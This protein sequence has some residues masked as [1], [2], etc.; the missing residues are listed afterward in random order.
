VTTVLH[1]GKF[2]PPVSG[3]MERV[4]ESLCRATADRVANRV[5]VFNE[6][7]R[8]VREVVD[9]V[10]VTRVGVLGMAG[11]VPIAP[12]L[13]FEL[14]R[15][16]ADLIVV[17]EP[18][19]WALLAIAAVRPSI[20]IAVWFHSE[21]VRPR[22][23]YN[24]FYHPLAHAVYTRARRFIVSSPAL[25]EQAGALAPFRD[26]ISV[27]P[28]GIDVEAWAAS[29][30]TTGRARE[31]RAGASGRPIILF[32]GRMVPYKGVDV[33]LRALQGLDAHLI[34]AGDGPSSAAWIAMAGALGLQDRVTFTGEVPQG[35]LQALFHACD[36][37]VLPS[38]TR[39]EAF[40]YVQL[41]AMSCGKPVVSTRVE[42]GVPWVNVH[43]ETGLT[44]PPGDDVALRDALRRLMDDGAL[45]ARMGMAGRNRVLKEFT[46]EAMGAKTAAVYER[47]RH[48]G[49]RVL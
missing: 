12:A 42:S 21:V 8:T 9:G 34:L 5:L 2:Y 23:Q 35:E 44:V 45:R 32:A 6:G 22:L 26:R 1:V 43:E 37:F 31:I 24:L 16:R 13:G 10:P 18:N 4:L 28:F 49:A 36:L 38:V 27:V 15:S 19:P 48:D 14:K 30:R 7:R 20:P 29:E 46:T 11:S 17:H 3:G 33:L 25:A 39:A 47:I 40:G 41:E